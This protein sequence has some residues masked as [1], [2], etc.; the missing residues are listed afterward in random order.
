MDFYLDNLGGDQ[1]LKK[2]PVYRSL[3][4]QD[5]VAKILAKLMQRRK[6]MLEELESTTPTGGN[7]WVLQLYSCE[8]VHK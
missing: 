5:K 2:R 6:F 3:G 1:F 4:E 8:Y 7:P